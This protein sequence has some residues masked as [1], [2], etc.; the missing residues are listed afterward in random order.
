MRELDEI[1]QMPIEY[2]DGDTILSL[3]DLVRFLKSGSRAVWWGLDYLQKVPH[4]Q[5]DYQAITQVS[6]QLMQ[7]SRDYAPGMV[8]SQLTRE[9]DKCDDKRP[10]MQDL[11]GS[12]QIEA[13]ARVVLG[14]YR[15]RIYLRMPEEKGNSR[16][17]VP[18]VR[19]GA[20]LG[21]VWLAVI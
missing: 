11:R 9:V 14:L 18:L 16:P 1:E 2:A 13:D 5:G 6:S 4:E 15:E 3:D 12:G 21:R 17:C 20:A 8:L 7:V 10:Q 19:P